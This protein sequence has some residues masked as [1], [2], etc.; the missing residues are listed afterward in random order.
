LSAAF[1]REV[2][3]RETQTTDDLPKIT[4][5]ALIA[6]HE[7]DQMRAVVVNQILNLRSTHDVDERASSAAI[8]MALSHKPSGKLVECRDSDRLQYVLSLADK[9]KMGADEAI[10]WIP[11]QRELEE[12]IEKVT[13]QHFP[14]G[15]GRCVTWQLRADAVLAQRAYPMANQCG[16]E[17]TVP[18]AHGLEG[19]AHAR[20]ARLGNMYEEEVVSIG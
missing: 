1:V 14:S 3:P 11:Y 17:E 9:M 5:K 12:P 4:G 2:N 20:P 18:S 10:P 13:R 7:I 8:H 6:T 19:R 15:D 16:K